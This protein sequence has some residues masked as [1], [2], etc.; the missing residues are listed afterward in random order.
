MASAFAHRLFTR[1]HV[2]YVRF[3]GDPTSSGGGFFAGGRKRRFA[4]GRVSLSLSLIRLPPSLSCAAL[5]G[6]TCMGNRRIKERR[7]W[8]RWPRLGCIRGE[9]SLLASREE[10]RRQGFE[11]LEYNY[12]EKE[13]REVDKI[14]FLEITHDGLLYFQKHTKFAGYTFLTIHKER[15]YFTDDTARIESACRAERVA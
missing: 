11:I 10:I 12:R 13:K 2:K 7:P 8:H 4:V 14:L 3:H 5:R 9:G 15:T 1:G 6:V